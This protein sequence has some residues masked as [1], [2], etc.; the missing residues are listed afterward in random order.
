MV[1]IILKSNSKLKII[2]TYYTL[3]SGFWKQMQVNY[4]HFYICFFFQIVF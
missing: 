1:S 3:P 2:F 4:A